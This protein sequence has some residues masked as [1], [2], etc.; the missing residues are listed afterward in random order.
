MKQGMSHMKACL[1]ASTVSQ[2]FLDRAAKR[3][4]D[5]IQLYCRMERN[6]P[7]TMN[8]KTYSLTA[9]DLV[10]EF[11]NA[12]LNDSQISI[13]AASSVTHTVKDIYGS[14]QSVTSKGVGEDV[15][16]GF[17]A[18]KGYGLSSAKQ[19][20]R[21][22]DPDFYETELSVISQVLAYF[23]ISSQRIMDVMP[24]IFETVFVLDFEDELRKNL[25][26]SLQLVGNVGL[27]TCRRMAKEEPDIQLRREELNERKKTLLRAATVV[28][29]FY[30]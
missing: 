18:A 12:R 3:A 5:Q 9:K 11:A 15:L 17:L 26:T 13:N 6:R 7:F 28:H 20:A 21:L 16:L 10:A 8:H 1:I 24:M 22:R 4:R 14:S 19:L 30:E 23:E 27:E 25:T 2:S 29:Q